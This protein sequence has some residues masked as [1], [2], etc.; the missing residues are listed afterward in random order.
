MVTYFEFI[1]TLS[2]GGIGSA[3]SYASAFI[4][5]QREVLRGVPSMHANCAWEGA[6]LY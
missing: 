6:S 1:G 4:P 5:V 3:A 2:F